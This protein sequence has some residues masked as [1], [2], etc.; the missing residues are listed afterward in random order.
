MCEHGSLGVVGG[1]FAVADLL[2]HVE[3]TGLAVGGPA[4][5]EFKSEI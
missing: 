2:T 4:N 1:E 5:N 3:I